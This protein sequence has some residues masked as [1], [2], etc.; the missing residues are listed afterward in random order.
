MH[1]CTCDSVHA[2][3]AG[4]RCSRMRSCPS[5]AVHV[6]ALA[7]SDARA[8]ARAPRT[9]DASTRTH[10]RTHAGTHACKR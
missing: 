5:D 1:G 3:S 8:R 2:K 7:R 10:A 9:L 6:S 4:P